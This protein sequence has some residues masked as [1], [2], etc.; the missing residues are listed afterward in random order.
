MAYRSLCRGSG[1]LSWLWSGSGLQR[2]CRNPET[3]QLQTRG[4]G[5]R[6]WRRRTRRIAGLNFNKLLV[7]I[8][9]QLSFGVWPHGFGTRRKAE[10][11]Y[12]QKR[13]DH[14]RFEHAGDS[15]MGIVNPQPIHPAYVNRSKKLL[16]NGLCGSYPKAD[17]GLTG[18]FRPARHDTVQKSASG[19]FHHIGNEKR[20]S[21]QDLVS[22]LADFPL[23]TWPSSSKAVSR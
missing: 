3:R 21:I 14:S 1:Q 18:G 9:S 20:A 11:D 6:H 7:E 17:T 8:V 15:F 12:K 4:S 13:K 23:P 2:R 16:D 19:K 10:Q 22:S 5:L